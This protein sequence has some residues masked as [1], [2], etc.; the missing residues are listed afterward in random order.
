MEIIQ[1]HMNSPCGSLYLVA[2]D[3]GLRAIHWQKQPSPIV[4]TLDSAKPAHKILKT[5][6]VQLKEYF[7]GRRKDF[8][9]PFDLDWGTS[10]QRSVWKELSRIPF[11]RT[12]SYKDIAK[13]IHNPKAVRAVGSANGRNPFSI[14]VPCHR[15]I[16]ADGSI[17]GYGGGLPAKR[18][19]LGL[20]NK[21]FIVD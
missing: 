3:K 17:G 6:T 4:K 13:R 10:F 5:T 12:V 9:L 2:S 20:E 1:F 19:L 14:I 16:A 11:G 21:Q 8:D 18:V 15:V 7:A